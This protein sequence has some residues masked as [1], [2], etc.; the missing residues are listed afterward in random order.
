MSRIIMRK[1]YGNAVL[2][3]DI[4]D[5]GNSIRKY[6][7]KAALFHKLTAVDY[8]VF[9]LV[10]KRSHRPW[11]RLFV[12]AFSRIEVDNRTK[13]SIDVLADS[14]EI[15]T[16]SLARVVFVVFTDVGLSG[17]PSGLLPTFCLGLSKCQS[18]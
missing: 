3:T 8:R 5:H 12:L 16:K 9:T 15:T 6:Q 18:L 1:Q 10:I 14:T 17:F 11:Q 4:D 7:Y 13:F 2:K